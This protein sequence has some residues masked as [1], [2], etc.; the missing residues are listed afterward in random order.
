MSFKRMVLVAMAGFEPA[1]TRLKDGRL[2]RLVHIAENFGGAYEYRTR[3]SPVD[4]RVPRQ[5]VY[6]PENT[7][8]GRK[9]YGREDLNLQVSRFV[10]GC[11]DPLNDARVKSWQP[12]MDSNHRYQ[13]SESCVLPLDDPAGWEG[14]TRTAVT[15]FKNPSPTAGRPPNKWG[16]RRESNSRGAIHSRT[17][18][19]LGH[20]HS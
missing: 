9:W 1:M 10:A 7:D 18:N 14:Q 15:G 4:S 2:S 12:G 11:P 13:L 6:A 3:L 16:D 19:P 5:L 8:R 17:P 20:G